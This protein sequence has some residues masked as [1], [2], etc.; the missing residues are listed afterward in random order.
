MPTRILLTGPVTFTEAIDISR[1]ML[2]A[3]KYP[4]KKAEFYGRIGSQI[5]LLTKAVA[6]HLRT[7]PA[8]VSISP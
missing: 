3:L 7:K 1:D 4:E 6:F 8:D 2:I 5:P